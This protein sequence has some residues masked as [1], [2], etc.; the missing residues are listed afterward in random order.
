M[1][2]AQPASETSCVFKNILNVKLTDEEKLPTI[3]I[4]LIT[5]LRQKPLDKY[6]VYGFHATSC[7]LGPLCVRI[8]LCLFKN[9]LFEVTKRIRVNK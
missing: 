2:E 3:R 6:C 4:S 1:T 5:H 8:Y 9:F 7:V